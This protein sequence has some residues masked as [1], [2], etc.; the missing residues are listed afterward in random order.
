M[1]RLGEIRNEVGKLYIEKKAIENRVLEYMRETDIKETPIDER[2]K[3][4]MAW[5]YDK[6]IDYERL[7]EL[8][9]DVYRMGLIATFS[10]TH[11]LMAVDGNLL[12]MILRDCTTANP[13]FVP[14]YEKRKQKKKRSKSHDQDDST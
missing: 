4:T 13:R 14:R 10:K 2:T 5:A 12:N 3:L 11:A 6:R 7:E 8:Y 1:R 9:P